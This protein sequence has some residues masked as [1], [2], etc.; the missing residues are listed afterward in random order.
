MIELLSAAK[1]LPIT[2][3]KLN[4]TSPEKNVGDMEL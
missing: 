4:E 1:Y 3:V 2:V